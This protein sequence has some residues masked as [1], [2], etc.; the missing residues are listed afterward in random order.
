MKKYL[1]KLIAFL[2]KYSALTHTF[3]IGWN[4]II[5]AWAT[6]S[7]ISLMDLG[8]GI[9][10]SINVRDVVVYVQAHAHIPTW[11]VGAFTFLANIT[12]AYAQWKKSHVQV[13]NVQPGDA[14]IIRNVDNDKVP[15]EQVKINIED[16]K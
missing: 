12:I 13:I 7:S 1:D 16:K 11:V 5:T 8:I 15:T 4:L 3:L 9:P 6:G 2:Q 10:Y 14:A